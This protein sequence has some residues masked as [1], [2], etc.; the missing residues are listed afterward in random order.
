[1]EATPLQIGWNSFSS[2]LSDQLYQAPPGRY[3]R[4]WWIDTTWFWVRPTSTAE[5]K[6][7]FASNI[8]AIFSQ[9]RVNQNWKRIYWLNDWTIYENATL[10]ATIAWTA[11]QGYNIGYM[12]PIWSTVYK[13]YYFHYTPPTINPKRIHRS[14]EDWTW[15]EENYK[16]YTA[17]TWNPFT[18]PPWQP[19]WMIVISEWERILFSYYN[20]IWQISNSEVVTKLIE[21]PS[22]QNVVWITEFQWEYKVYTTAW[23]STSK[24]YRWDWLSNL[25]DLSIDLKGLAIT[26]W[27]WSLWAYDY[28]IAD[29]SFYQVAWVQ[30]QELY[31]GINGRIV[32]SYD[33]KI[34]I[35]MLQPWDV[36]ALCEYS[37]RPW[38][39]KWIHPI[40]IIDINSKDNWIW[41]IDYNQSWLIFASFK[42]LYL[43]FWT[44]ETPTTWTVDTFI[45]SLTFIWDNIQFRKKIDNAIFKFSWFTTQNISFYA[46]I[47]N[48]WPWIKIWEWNNNSVSST[49][50]GIQLPSNSFLNQLWNFNTIRFKVVMSHNWTRQWTFYWIDLFGKQN[51]W[52]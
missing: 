50:Y 29:G 51:I 36:M 27:V 41:A 43:Q 39:S 22:E 4:G 16:D 42:K 34:I 2:W 8:N 21:F 38:Y 33:N 7:T 9:D 32:S 3:Y 26:G 11:K 46:E 35:E 40:T 12:K 20:T 5:L 25:P 24:I 37:N 15:F 1:M 18:S 13:L 52:K 17:N 10:R 28:F 6:H 49:N 30:Y 48:N 19:N 44:P 14:N 47:N 45:E 31:R 23:F